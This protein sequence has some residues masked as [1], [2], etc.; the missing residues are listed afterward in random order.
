MFVKKNDSINRRLTSYS[1]L[2]LTIIVIIAL[3]NCFKPCHQ[4]VMVSKSYIININ[5]NLK[6]NNI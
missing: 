3:Q 1:V 4:F 2:Y 5:A 6:I